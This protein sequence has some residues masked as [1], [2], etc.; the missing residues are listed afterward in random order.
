M[1]LGAIMIA[2]CQEKPQ[3]QIWEQMQEQADDPVQIVET[4]TPVP[5][6]NQEVVPQEKREVVT[7]NIIDTID[8]EN[9][10][11]YARC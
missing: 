9:L 4:S 7:A 6:E 1:L 3:E 5:E 10:K 2:G 8:A 11:L